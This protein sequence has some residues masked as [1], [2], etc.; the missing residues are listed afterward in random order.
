MDYDIVVCGAGAFG[1][2]V[3]RSL[4]ELDPKPR[5]VLIDENY[6]G[7]VTAS[8][9]PFKAIRY[10]YPTEF[11]TKIAKQDVN[12]WTKFPQYYQSGWLRICE[13]PLPPH[14]AQFEKRID[15]HDAKKK[16]PLLQ[17][18]NL[19]GS[20]HYYECSDP[21]VVKADDFLVVELEAAKKAG[22]ETVSGKVTGLIK[23]QD[24]STKG[25]SYQDLDGEKQ[26]SAEKVT[27]AMGARTSQFCE[28]LGIPLP[29][30]FV[31]AGIAMVV[32]ELPP[33]TD[34]AAGPLPL[35]MF[36]DV[37]ILGPIAGNTVI[38]HNRKSFAD[39][40][41]STAVLK[42]DSTPHQQLTDFIRKICPKLMQFP[43]HRLTM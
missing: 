16:N 42:P 38:V 13:N 25:V 23:G 1:I 7:S 27:I 3:V 36:D 18:A 10:Q 39:I 24:G 12:R 8:R 43:M 31:S 30:G 37:E 35:L 19:P 32:F 4:I 29:G 20:T 22:V 26:I 21:G 11:W 17:D 34:T 40:S 2:S 33:D 15:E 14:L 28:K 41:G 9:S 5:I 6:S